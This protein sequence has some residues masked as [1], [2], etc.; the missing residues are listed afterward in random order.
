MFGIYC[1]SVR[2]GSWAATDYDYAGPDWGGTCRYFRAED[3]ADDLAELRRLGCIDP[4]AYVAPLPR[5]LILAYTDA[6]LAAAA[7]GTPRVLAYMA[8]R[9]A[10]LCALAAWLASWYAEPL[11]GPG[12]FGGPRDWLDDSDRDF[13]VRKLR[14][15][16][17]AYLRGKLADTVARRS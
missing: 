4:A 13:F 7:M 16:S 10:G 5:V 11:M 12:P 2:G 14:G 6:N 15:R 9:K 17:L 8:F 3:A 1:P